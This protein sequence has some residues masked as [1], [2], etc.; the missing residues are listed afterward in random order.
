MIDFEV[1]RGDL[2]GALLRN[3]KVAFL[4]FKRWKH[5]GAVSNWFAGKSC[6]DNTCCSRRLLLRPRTQDIGQGYPQKQ[7]IARLTSCPGQPGATRLP[8]CPKKQ[9]RSSRGSMRFLRVSVQCATAAL[10]IPARY[11]TPKTRPTYKIAVQFPA[12]RMLPLSLSS[13]TTREGSAGY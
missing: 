1:F 6:A 7:G 2:E 10:D 13:S 9:R 5:G 11:T 3:R 4:P 12:R 8:H